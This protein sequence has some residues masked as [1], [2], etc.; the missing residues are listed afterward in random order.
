MNVSVL[1]YV[2]NEGAYLAS[3][4]ES[5]LN[6][7][8]RDL[9]LCVVDDGSTDA[10]P[11]VLARAA[12]RDAR[13][14]VERQEH[15][16]SDR[17]HETFNNA[18]AMTR[19]D[20]IA[21]AN[22]DDLWRPE[23]VA[24]QVAA[25]A[26][27]PDLDICHHDATFIDAADRVIHGSFRRV[28]SPLP[29]APPRPWQ[30]VGGNPIPNPTVM[31]HRAIL[32]RIGLQ[33]L[34][35]MHDTQFWF[36][37]TIHGCRF[38]GLPDRL[39]KYRV[40]EASEST[41]TSRSS[42][43]ARLHRACARAM[44]ERHGLDELYP[45]LGAAGD[46][47]SRAW[48]WSHL[49]ALF[50]KR[51]ALDSATDAW[52]QALR[53]SDNAAVVGN[54]GAVAL[55]KGETH[56]ARQL[57]AAAAGEYRHARVL[58]EDPAV[59]HDL[60][61]DVWAGPPPPVADLVAAGARGELAPTRI[62]RLPAVDATVIVDDTTTS[63]SIASALFGL[64]ER[65]GHAPVRLAMLAVGSHTVPTIVEAYAQ[66]ERGAA[67]LIAGAEIDVVPVQPDE[68]D[69]VVAAHVLDGAEIVRLGREPAPGTA[70]DVIQ[71]SVR[72]TSPA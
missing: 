39:I 32:R 49:G 3:L 55:R 6:Q 19:H 17:L 20:L 67:D 33:E 43:I 21:V 64:S 50:W 36:K 42:R 66:L 27:D 38:L 63:I 69:S 62:P 52:S 8:H 51:S 12:A 10:T 18:L 1:L 72:V 70:D 16:G 5:I 7:T 25:F 46:A 60:L 26:T 4:V 13:V 59:V 54:L 45:E 41:A 30:F 11:T 24:T 68:V 56:R 37:A 65:C 29:A 34:G 47:D 15:H 53:L 9:E 48:A 44:V 58:L 40:H 57:L 23:K 31:F 2:H 61:L 28:D 35:Q 22:G 71:S 14:R